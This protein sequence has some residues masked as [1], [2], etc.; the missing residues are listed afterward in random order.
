ML[1]ESTRRL[2]SPVNLMWIAFVMG[3]SSIA[4]LGRHPRACPEDLP[5]S[6]VIPTRRLATLQILGTSPRMTEAVVCTPYNS[7]TRLR[8]SSLFRSH[9]RGFSRS[10]CW[11][12]RPF[13][14]RARRYRIGLLF[15][16]LQPRKSTTGN[17]GRIHPLGES[18]KRRG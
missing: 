5:T 17:F 1:N 6:S 15:A 2:R 12:W 16:V 3:K 8:G 14:A 10:R 18:H 11:V 7:H 4:W 13:A 9:C